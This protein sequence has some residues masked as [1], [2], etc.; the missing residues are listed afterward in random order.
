MALSLTALITL[1]RVVFF[2]FCRSLRR[3]LRG[4]KRQ[5]PLFRFVERL[6][7][8]IYNASLISNRPPYE[9]TFVI[10]V[11]IWWARFHNAVLRRP[12][13]IS[14]WALKSAR[15]VHLSIWWFSTLLWSWSLSIVTISWGSTWKLRCGLANQSKRRADR[16]LYDYKEFPPKNYTNS[17]AWT[18]TFN[19]MV[20]STGIHSACE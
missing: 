2:F 18:R 9:Y 3:A 10:R 7:L 11:G 17:V 1:S 16:N 19:C 15:L 20:T 13:V 5:A 14:L 6:V 12:M 4:L 8:N